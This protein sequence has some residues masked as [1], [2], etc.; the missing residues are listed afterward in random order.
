[1]L[2]KIKGLFRK[3]KLFGYSAAGLATAV[4]A[5]CP[6]LAYAGS[7]SGS[8]GSASTT[9]DV[10]SVTTPISNFFT[11]AGKVLVILG[12]LVAVGGIITYILG[13]SSGNAQE[14]KTGQIAI[15]SG[16]LVAVVSGLFVTIGNLVLGIS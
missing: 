2:G 12:L 4:A 11:T 1:M 6:K 10:S 13:N 3:G 8:G 7:G 14:K 5:S 15:L 16:V 9:I